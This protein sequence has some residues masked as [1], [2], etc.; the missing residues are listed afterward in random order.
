MNTIT[1]EELNEIRKD[2][3]QEDRRDYE[4]EIMLR[5]DYD[6]AIEK[7]VDMDAVTSVDNSIKLLNSLGH[8]SIDFKD[9]RGLL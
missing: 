9:L 1:Q 7:L 6:Y 8:E 3:I 4:E 2:M 5:R